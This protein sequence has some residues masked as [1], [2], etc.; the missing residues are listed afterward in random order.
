MEILFYFGYF[1]ESKLGSCYLTHFLITTQTQIFKSLKCENLQLAFP[2]EVL[3]WAI[4]YHFTVSFQTSPLRFPASER[5]YYTAKLDRVLA[6]DLLFCNSMLKRE[7][8]ILKMYSHGEED[9]FQMHCRSLLAAIRWLW[10]SPREVNAVWGVLQLCE[11]NHRGL[12]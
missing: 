9:V 3:N 10:N 12:I 7:E 1:K 6:L 5:R 4:Q 8:R 2:L 11:R